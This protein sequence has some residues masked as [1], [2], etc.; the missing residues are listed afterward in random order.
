MLS[1]TTPQLCYFSKKAVTDNI[2]TNERDCVPIKPY[3]Q[4]QVAG[5]IW[6]VG[7]NLPI[8]GITDTP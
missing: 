3:L 5:W 6:P 8:S 4:T 7:Y 1:V 2:Q